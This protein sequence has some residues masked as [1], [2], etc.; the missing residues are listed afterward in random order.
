MSMRK[1]VVAL[2]ALTACKGDQQIGTLDG[3]TEWT[4]EPNNEIDILFVVDNSSSMED[5][6]AALA[7][8]FQSFMA[9]M[10]E[11]NDYQIGVVSTSV[12]YNDL[13]T[14]VLISNDG[15]PQPWIDIYDPDP[16]GHFAR[17]SA[18]GTG[19]SDKEKG[20]EVAA[21]ALSDAMVVTGPN[22]GFLRAAAKL[23]VVVVS[24]EEDCSD[25]GTLESYPASACYTEKDQLTPVA[26]LVEDI[27]DAKDDGDD[28]IIHV[29]VG[30]E[31]STCADAYPGRRYME[32]AAYTGGLIG[33]ICNGDWSG[34]LQDLGLN[35]SGVK[36][37]FRL[38]EPAVPESLA[39][40]VDDKEIA[41][42]ANNGWTYDEETCFVTFHGME[43]ASIPVRGATLHAEYTK[44]SGGSAA[45][46]KGSL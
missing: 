7:T 18:L 3:Y 39:V 27:S 15:D 44:V 38:D 11:N 19:G 12:D 45:D 1:G 20:L 43:G 2:L 30:T 35:A 40:F 25:A 14:G 24:D 4:Q 41:E 34:V 17:L 22:A 23:L 42:N 9:A 37:S 33:D 8:G 28:A 36:T 16:T 31:D 21:L 26:S 32:A 6:Q 46:C 13:N 5:E 10:G 29:I